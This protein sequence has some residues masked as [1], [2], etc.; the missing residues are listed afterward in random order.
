VLL[1]VGG[2]E[3]AGFRVPRLARR[4][5]SRWGTGRGRGREGAGRGREGARL[6]RR[7]RC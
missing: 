6:V 7:G 1:P 4:Q 5:T 3:G 2:A